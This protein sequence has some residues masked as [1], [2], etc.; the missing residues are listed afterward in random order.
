ML[1]AVA[2]GVWLLARGGGPAATTLQATGTVEA[3]EAVLG[4]AAAG[5]IAEIPVHEGDV[6][7][8]HVVL[9]V[10]DTAEL[11][12]RLRLARAQLTVA[13]AQLRDLESGARPQEVEDRRQ[14]VSAAQRTLDEAERD[15]SRVRQ[16][17][18]Q[19]I[20]SR[21]S[22]DAAQTARDVAAARLEQARQALALA[23][24]G[25]RAG[26][27]DAARAGRAVASAQVAA[28]QATVPDY[29][30]RSPFAGLV[31]VRAREPGESVTPG[32]PVVT[33][34]DMDDR[35]VRIYVPENR[36]GAAR[37]GQL[38]TITADAFPGRS[39]AG[40]VTWISEEAE[41]TPRNI[42]TQDERVKLVYAVKVEIV[43]DSGLALKPGMPADVRVALGAR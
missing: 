31:T 1:A 29:F 11:M 24:S 20:A 32:V 4:F 34:L 7:P 19:E 39:F 36:A 13:T 8:A 30:I 38:A 43:G 26:Q 14:A 22:L 33:L 17:A 3:T 15:L 23:E 28:L 16:L 18:L 6:V 10:L 5:R 25:Y 21:Q 35:W 12:A 37:I 27:V 9:A 41:F 2:V 40:R 42:Q